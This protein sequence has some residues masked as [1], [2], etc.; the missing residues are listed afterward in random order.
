MSYGNELLASVGTSTP[1]MQPGFGPA[2]SKV[3]MTL[4]D[5][6]DVS[7]ESLTV[8]EQTI[9][10][11]AH[12]NDD[13][14]RRVKEA[15]RRFAECDEQWANAVRRAHS[16]RKDSSSEQEGKKTPPS[17]PPTRVRQGPD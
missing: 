1:A 11:L 15:K 7:R 6:Q 4:K 2:L 10:R 9:G 14:L 5:L 13:D 3:S 12:S 17:G 16:V 8:T